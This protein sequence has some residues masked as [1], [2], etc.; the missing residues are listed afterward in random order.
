MSDELVSLSF[1]QKSLDRQK[2]RLAKYNKKGIGDRLD[3][4]T[5]AG[6]ALL[7]PPTRAAAPLGKTGNLRRKVRA[8]KGRSNEHGATLSSTD[9]VRHLVIRPHRIVTPGGRD[10][11]RKTSGNSFIDAAVQ[12]RLD[13]AKAEIQKV[14][15]AD[16]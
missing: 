6:L 10:T 16:D 3:K 14:L 5:Q 11:G 15:F 1:D 4:G 8:A 7:V 13:Q 12:P 9:P 2:A